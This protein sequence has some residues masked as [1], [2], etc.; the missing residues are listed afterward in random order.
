M[1]RAKSYYV[2]GHVGS[3]LHRTIPA[4]TFRFS[5]IT[6]YVADIFLAM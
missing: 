2:L 5:K 3:Q 1:F 6:D 4:Q